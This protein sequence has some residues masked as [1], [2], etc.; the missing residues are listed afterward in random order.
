MI[1]LYALTSPNVQKIF[2]M[3]EELELPYRIT[4]VDVWKG[5]QFDPNFLKIN[6]NAKV[7]V[8]VDHEGPGGRP[9]TLFESGAILMYLAEK[10]GRL[11]P[12]EV[13]ARYEVIQWLML[14]VASIGPIFGQVVHFTRFAPAGND[15]AVSR[16]RTEA[17]RLFELYEKRLGEAAWVG[18]SD[19]SIAD[20]AAFPWLRNTTLLGIGLDGKPKLKQWVETINARPAI[21][22]ALEKIAAIKSSRDTATQDNLD[23]LFGRGRYARA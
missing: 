14:Q 16:Y 18:G 19:Y 15:Y 11:L 2:F 12:K 20:I 10:S 22:R 3:L 23:R 1:D 8:I 5:E 13:A 6:P 7:P 17:R 21:A 9:Y 4:P